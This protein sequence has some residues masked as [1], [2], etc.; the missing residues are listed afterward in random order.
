MLQNDADFH[1]LIVNARNVNELIRV[2][3]RHGI[4]LTRAL[5]RDLF[6]SVHP[7]LASSEDEQAE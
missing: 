2:A 5:A 1:Q 7:E 6:Y 4:K 3:K